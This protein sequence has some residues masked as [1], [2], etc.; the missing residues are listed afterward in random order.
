MKSLDLYPIAGVRFWEER[1]LNLR[2][3]IK[4]QFR[5]E[6][7]QAARNLNNAWRFFQVEAP[8]LIPKSFMSSSYEEGDYFL[9]DFTAAEEQ[10]AL[11][12][13]TTHGSYTYAKHLFKS[14]AVKPPVCIWQSGYS[15]RTENTDGATAA[16]LRFNQFN[17]LEFQFIYGVGTKADYP[18]VFRDVAGLLVHS[19]TGRETRVVPSDR[20]PSY[21]QETNDIE[22]LVVAGVDTSWREVASLSLRTDFG[23]EKILVFEVAL[24]LDRLVE[25][26]L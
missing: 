5:E 21:S 3:R 16:K 6:L 9:T 20:L 18:K 4:N 26:A 13:E 7:Y 8:V 22:V 23:D 1:E 11:R 12:A 14:S 24:G 19:I 17:Q 10:W 15:F 2:E 25:L